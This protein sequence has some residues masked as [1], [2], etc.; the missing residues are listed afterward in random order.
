M[1]NFENATLLSYSH[2]PKFLGE[3]FVY[4]IEKE[5]TVK[6]VIADFYNTSGA[7]GVSSGIYALVNL[8]NSSDN[9]VLNG[10]NFGSGYIRNI[11]IED[12]SWVRRGEYTA[13]ILILSS[14]D[15]YNMTGN[16][17][18]GL[19]NFTG[20]PIHLMN[21]FSENF[22]LNLDSENNYNYEHSVSFSF[23]NALIYDGADLL[24]KQIAS[25]IM[26]K[27]VPFNLI[28]GNSNFLSGKKYYEE[29]YDI[30]NKQFSF[31]ESLTKNI[32]GDIADANFSYSLRRDENGI[33]EVTEAIQILANQSP[34]FGTLK[35]KL[36]QLKAA[37]YQRSQN[38]Y[39][40]YLPGYLNNFP[41]TQGYDVDRFDGSIDFET[42]YTDNP[43]IDNRYNWS[44]ETSVN[45][46]S[47]YEIICSATLSVEGDGVPN[48]VKKYDNSLY[49]YNQKKSVLLTKINNLYSRYLSANTNRCSSGDN[50]NK[51]SESFTSSRYNGN[52]D[53]TI[54]YT[55][56]DIA[57]N[58][59][60]LEEETESL[61][62]KYPLNIYTDYYINNSVIRQKHDQKSFYEVTATKNRKYGK[63]FILES[64][65]EDMRIFTSKIKTEESISIN[66]SERTAT[67]VVTTVE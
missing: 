14:G 22:S 28:S 31:N 59:N 25:G 8:A 46:D 5:L 21:D 23:E 64:F 12:G 66:P 47:S 36:S 57:Y 65:P 33:T 49:G 40:N 11:S 1:I 17:F 6:G 35:T 32:S 41:I 16:Y 3:N 55:N 63:N 4:A 26:G 51:K 61:S 45:T 56:K 34:K 42:V 67:Y 54:T 52:I 29:S 53:Y 13:D 30:I 9:I 24:A 39:A 15:L 27:E 60:G 2:S 20:L 44:I 7:S 18:T 10:I 50:L 37:S 58:P 38:F 62:E 19:Q 48:T 43:F